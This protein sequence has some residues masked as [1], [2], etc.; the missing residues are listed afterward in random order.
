MRRISITAEAGR[1][2][3]LHFQVFSVIRDVE[4]L[5]GLFDLFDAVL[6]RLCRISSAYKD[7]PGG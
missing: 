3:E 2:D 4:R 6:D 5:K 1:G 7:H